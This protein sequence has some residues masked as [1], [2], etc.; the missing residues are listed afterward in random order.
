M[1]L[2]DALRGLASGRGRG[3]IEVPLQPGEVLIRR[4]IAS[5]N[6]GSPT[7]IG[8][9]LLVTNQRV[10]FSPLDMRD[11]VE[12]LTWGLNKAGAPGGTDK[13]IGG[14]GDMVTGAA[15]ETGLGGGGSSARAGE[16]PSH[17]KPPTLIIETAEGQLQE[18]GI[19]AAGSRG[20]GPPRTRGSET[21]PS[22]RSA[23]P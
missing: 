9:D 8:G 22:R 4:S 13:A 10:V 17:F 6:P 18:I 20:T 19:L 3:A 7:G 16:K 23:R 2:M 21:W 12:V 11:L 1:G 15:S 14:L 5:V